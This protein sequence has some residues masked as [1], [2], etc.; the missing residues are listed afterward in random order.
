[1]W[2]YFYGPDTVSLA[3]HIALRDVGVDLRL[4]RVDMKAGGQ[5]SADYLALN[6]KGRVPTLITPHGTLTETPAILAF[7]AQSFPAAGLIPDDPYEFARVQEFNCYIAS[8]LH[9]AHAH[10]FRGHRW[11]DDKD[12]IRAMREKVPQTVA[13]A[14]A[15]IEENYL[16]GPFVMG[17]SYSIADPYL[18]T[19][20]RW[21]ESDGVDPALFPKVSAHRAMMMTRPSVKRALADVYD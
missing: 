18:F 17:D 2:E 8:T 16:P 12:A 4:H 10:K 19:V 3:P 21:I 9:V 14:F 13:A 7:V 11:V 6:P 1:M 15:H 5:T 20:S